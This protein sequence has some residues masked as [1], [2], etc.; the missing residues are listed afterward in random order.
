MA[1]G[2]IAG[3][4]YLYRVSG[5][6]ARDLEEAQEHGDALSGSEKNFGKGRRRFEIDPSEGVG[7]LRLPV[8]KVCFAA[9]CP[10]NVELRGLTKIPI[11]LS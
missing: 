9:R 11:V 7:G 2:L 8:I 6:R 10:P 5:I 4:A 3:L 1:V